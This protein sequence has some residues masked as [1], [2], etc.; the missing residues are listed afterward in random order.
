[1]DPSNSSTVED[2]PSSLTEGLATNQEVNDLY[3]A[4]SAR[5]LDV[6]EIRELLLGPDPRLTIDSI[7][8]RMEKAEK[9]VLKKSRT[10]LDDWRAAE[11]RLAEAKAVRRR[12]VRWPVILAIATIA[13]AVFLA[14]RSSPDRHFWVLLGG[15]A[16]LVGTF[17]LAVVEGARVGP[18]KKAAKA[19]RARFSQVLDAQTMVTAREV[20]NGRVTSYSTVFRVLDSS[21]LRQMADPDREV[22]TA[23]IEELAQLIRSLDGGSIGL[24]GP[25]G[26]GKTVL[27]RSFTEGRSIPFPKERV[28]LMVSAPVK[29]DALEFVLHLFGKLCEHVIDGEAN[30][31]SRPGTRWRLARERRVASLAAIFGIL[32]LAAG[33]AVRWNPTFSRTDVGLGLALTG[34]AIIYVSGLSWLVLKLAAGPISRGAKR[35]DPHPEEVDTARRNREERQ[36]EEHLTRIRFQQSQERGGSTKV[37]LFGFEFGGSAS[38]TLARVPWTL[39]EAVD[40]LRTFIGDL[41][42]R[43]LIIGIDELD[44]METTDVAREFLNNVKGIF[45]VRNCYYLVSISEDAMGAFERR[46]LPVRDVFDSSFDEVQSV[47]YLSLDES[48]E[49]LRGRV[50]GLPVP[51]QCLCHCISGGL[52]R[53]LIRVTRELVNHPLIEAA[54]IVQSVPTIGDLAGALIAAEWRAKLRAAIFSG[55]AREETRAWW[56]TEWLHDQEQTQD[57][58]SGE[59]RRLSLEI[60]DHLSRPAADGTARLAQRI[61]VELIAFNYF[62]ATVLDLFAAS[63]P[64]LFG[65]EALGPD[66]EKVVERLAEARQE[67]VVDPWLSWGL[68]EDSRTMLTADIWPIELPAGYRESAPAD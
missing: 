23:A 53:D 17:W 37:N 28:G 50:I 45:G 59:L 24:S 44:K 64:R 8:E 38:K 12:R 14:T 9:S 63:G 52:P 60:G 15:A 3:S 62:A 43:F 5:A 48:R 35:K 4:A 6:P 31:K 19:A 21:G 41:S 49:L 7:R 61:A 1:L 51:Y 34:G 26:S 54:A 68:V 47:G 10:M 55:R 16:W 42:G 40:E 30:E 22:S 36:A 32:L 67:F 20:I 57:V 18:R 13:A 65:G 25:R 56:L 27:I 2:P 66:T 33:L 29:Y 11:T 58:T 46:G 39:P